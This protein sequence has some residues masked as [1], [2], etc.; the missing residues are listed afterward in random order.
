MPQASD[1][2]GWLVAS[3]VI[4]VDPVIAHQLARE[5]KEPRPRMITLVGQ[6]DRDVFG[7]SEN[8]VPPTH[9]V[10]EEAPL[11]LRDGGS[12]P[13]RFRMREHRE[14][15]SSSISSARPATPY[16]ST[17]LRPV[18]VLS[19]P[20]PEPEPSRCLAHRGNAL[21]AGHAPGPVGESTRLGFRSAAWRSQQSDAGDRH[22]QH[23]EQC[24][25]DLEGTEDAAVGRGD[26]ERPE[27]VE[28]A[29]E[30]GEAGQPGAGES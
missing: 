21:L 10:V 17:A 22:P 28:C 6:R 29:A 18:D 2:E 8:A 12:P 19:D 23:E 16:V 14:A 11:R 4:A 26:R 3:S 7:H 20:H 30:Q 1:R 27:C 24:P 5:R 9:D 13:S 25:E 15:S